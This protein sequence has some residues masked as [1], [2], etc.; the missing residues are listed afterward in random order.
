VTIQI[1]I[2]DHTSP[3]APDYIALP[4]AHRWATNWARAR[5]KLIA[6]KMPSADKLLQDAARPALSVPDPRGSDRLDQL[7]SEHRLLW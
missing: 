2:G 1:N 3:Y 7:R 4:F 6:A 5:A